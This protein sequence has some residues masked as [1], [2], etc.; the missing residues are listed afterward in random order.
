MNVAAVLAILGFV[1]IQ[2]NKSVDL[3]KMLV[4]EPHLRT[5]FDTLC[6]QSMILSLFTGS[7]VFSMWHMSLLEDTTSV[8]IA[9]ECSM[10]I[11]V[12]WLASGGLLLRKAQ[13]QMRQW[14]GL[15]QA[16][17]NSD[18]LKLK[19]AEYER[20]YYQMQRDPQMALPHELISEMQ[21]LVQ[22]T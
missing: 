21:H 9:C 15:E 20:L 16:A 8:Y 5:A 12:F 14:R 17:T 7:L 11:V 19:E 22:R 1:A 10:A 3:A 6:Q 13:L 2:R 18:V 4:S